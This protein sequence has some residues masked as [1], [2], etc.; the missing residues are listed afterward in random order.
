MYMLNLSPN[1]G[2]NL[3]R[4][5]NIVFMSGSHVQSGIVD[6]THSECIGITNYLV[7]KEMLNVAC[8]N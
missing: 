7:F 3:N 2:L 8:S 5:E 4:F 1:E 6:F